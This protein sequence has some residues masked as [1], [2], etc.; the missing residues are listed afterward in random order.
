GETHARRGRGPVFADLAVFATQVLGG[1]LHRRDE[2]PVG[3]AFRHCAGRKR[4][5]EVRHVWEVL[6]V[7]G[8]HVK[9]KGRNPEGS[10]PRSALSGPWGPGFGSEVIE[11]GDGGREEVPG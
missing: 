7:W 9:A 4:L 8:P 2:G 6:R 11:R 3:M 5:G 1:F 10:R